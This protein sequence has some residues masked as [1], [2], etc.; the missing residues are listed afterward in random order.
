M[1][2]LVLTLFCRFGRRI[3]NFVCM[4]V[5][6]VFCLIVLAVP[7]SKCW[8]NYRGAGGGGEGGKVFQRFPPPRNG[9]GE[10]GTDPPNH[11]KRAVLYISTCGLSLLLVLSLAP[12]GFSVGTP[13]FPL[14]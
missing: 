4:I 6:G 3:P 14:P 7:A 10:E 8:Y 11:L 9:V 12:R 1:N 2:I 5:G 13:V